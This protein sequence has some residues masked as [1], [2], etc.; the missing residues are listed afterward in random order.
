MVEKKSIRCSH[1]KEL[2]IKC[3]CGDKIFCKCGHSIDYHRFLKSAK[4]DACIFVIDE[5]K[6]THHYCSCSNF[7]EVK[8]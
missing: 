2:V 5:K 4:P 3:L 8:K 1:C 7:E 6:K